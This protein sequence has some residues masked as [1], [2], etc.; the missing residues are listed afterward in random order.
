MDSGSNINIETEKSRLSNFQPLD[1]HVKTYG[2]NY[3][4][5]Q[6]KGTIRVFGIQMECFYVPTHDDRILSISQLTRHQQ[7]VCFVDNQAI[8]IP[9]HYVK[10]KQLRATLYDMMNSDLPSEGV[11]HKDPLQLYY[12]DVSSDHSDALITRVDRAKQESNTLSTTLDTPRSVQLIKNKMGTFR[13]NKINANSID[14]TMVQ[15]PQDRILKIHC[16]L[17]HMHWKNICKN[18]AFIYHIRSV[19]R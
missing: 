16:A 18:L 11:V 5:A 12:L 6:G 17:G 9:F 19:K 7:L 14:L 3:V 15:A 1:I 13:I 10:N 8:V 4:L 2:N